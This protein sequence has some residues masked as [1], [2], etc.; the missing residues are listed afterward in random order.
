MLVPR[1]SVEAAKL[2]VYIRKVGVSNPAGAQIILTEIFCGVLSSSS[3][4]PR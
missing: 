4:F 2:L 3:E 1:K